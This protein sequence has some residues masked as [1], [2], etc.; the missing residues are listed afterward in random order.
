MVEL[1]FHIYCLQD[2]YKPKCHPRWWWIL[3][4][5]ETGQHYQ[6]FVIINNTKLPDTVTKIVID[7]VT[8]WLKAIF[9][10]KSSDYGQTDRVYHRISAGEVRLIWQPPRR[11]PIAKQAEVGKILEDTQWWGIIEESNSSWSLDML[12]RAKW[13]ST[14]DLRSSYWHVVLHPDDKESTAFLMGQGLWQ[15]MVMPFGLCCTPVMFEKLMET[16][17]RGLTSHGLCTWMTWLCLATCSENNCTTY[18]KYS[19]DS[20]RPT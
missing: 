1:W 8:W 20:E 7:I 9:A 17:L 10:M 11:L 16:I 4:Q 5:L 13:F 3:T 19:S 12:A 18:R 2:Q 6:N 14:L 15:F